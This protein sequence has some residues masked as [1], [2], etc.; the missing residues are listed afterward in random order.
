MVQLACI[1]ID[2]S[3]SVLLIATT[4]VRLLLCECTRLLLSNLVVP[5]EITGATMVYMGFVLCGGFF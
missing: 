3:S 2:L 4:I 5:L 1:L